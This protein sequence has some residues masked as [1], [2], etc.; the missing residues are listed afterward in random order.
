MGADLTICK[1]GTY[2]RDSYNDGN[3]WWLV[4]LSYWEVAKTVSENK[5][6]SEEGR[7]SLEGVKFVNGLVKDA[8]V[9]TF[10]QWFAR[11][12][13]KSSTRDAR[14][15]GTWVVDTSPTPADKELYKF[16]V[17]KFAESKSFWAEAEAAESEVEWS[18]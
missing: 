14:V 9:P 15:A 13:A 7:L 6:V 16:L 2:F 11:K 1:T 5:F 3:S 12:Q 18:V 8:K 4:D 10:K 17:E